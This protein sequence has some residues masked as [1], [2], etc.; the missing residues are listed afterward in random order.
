[1]PA[2]FQA[3]PIEVHQPQSVAGTEVSRALLAC[4]V[5]SKELL[6]GLITSGLRHSPASINVMGGKRNG[7]RGTA[8][9]WGL[10]SAY[11]SSAGYWLIELL[12]GYRAV[13]FRFFK[14]QTFW[15]VNCAINR[16]GF[17]AR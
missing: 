14:K 12:D 3:A 15:R 1:M 10:W 9:G 8:A 16:S 7:I 13:C 2:E 4:L 5:L 11:D 17:V 6:P